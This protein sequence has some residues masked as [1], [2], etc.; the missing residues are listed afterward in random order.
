MPCQPVPVPCPVVILSV[1][2]L[3]ELDHLVNLAPGL[4]PLP[5][6]HYLGAGCP[7]IDQSPCPG[8]LRREVGTWDDDDD[9]VSM[10]LS[11]VLNKLFNL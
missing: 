5:D 2:R 3:P 10:K 9:L 1:D 4:G 8:L 6:I 11:V 7:P